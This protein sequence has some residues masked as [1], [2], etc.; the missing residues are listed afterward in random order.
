MALDDV[1]K[2]SAII[3]SGLYQWNM[4]PFGLMNATNTFSHTMVD[5]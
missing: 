1:K 5:G 2:T 3:K 4:M